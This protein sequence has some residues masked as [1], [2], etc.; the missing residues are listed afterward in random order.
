MPGHDV[1]VLRVPIHVSYVLYLERVS[2]PLARAY[3]RPRCAACRVARVEPSIL[4]HPLDFLGGDDAARLGPRVLPRHG[5]P[6]ERRSGA[7]RRLPP[8]L[9]GR[10]SSAHGRPRRRPPERPTPP[11]E[12]RRQLDLSAQPLACWEVYGS[13]SF[14]D[15]LAFRFRETGR[16]IVPLLLGSFRRPPA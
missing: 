2:P 15:I 3:F 10:G 16:F 7:R 1:A 4:L 8:T 11:G 12:G 13:G 14:M 5:L 9:Q 6:G